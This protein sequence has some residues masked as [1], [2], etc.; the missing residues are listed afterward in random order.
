MKRIKR[1]AEPFRYFFGKDSDFNFYGKLFL[2]PMIL[3]VCLTISVLEFFFV[4]M[5]D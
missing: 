3:V 5:D 4:K 2:L 1:M